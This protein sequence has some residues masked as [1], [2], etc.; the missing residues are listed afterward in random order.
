MECVGSCLDVRQTLLSLSGRLFHTPRLNTFV[1]QKSGLT[2]CCYPQPPSDYRSPSPQQNVMQST[3]RA[4]WRSSDHLNDSI[5]SQ[6]GTAC[7]SAVSPPGGWRMEGFHRPSVI[8]GGWTA[9]RHSDHDRNQQAAV[10]LGL[11]ALLDPCVFLA[12]YTPPEPEWTM[13]RIDE[14]TNLERGSVILT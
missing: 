8:V 9:I 13:H 10:Q 5:I 1:Y 2:D 4:S 14:A 7:R 6:G 12:Q 11:F 3:F